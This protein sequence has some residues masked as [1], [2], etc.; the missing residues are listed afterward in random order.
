MNRFI[1]RL[2]LIILITFTADRALSYVASFF[3]SR[4][5]TTDEYK[6]NAVT[7]NMTDP[8]VLMG[9]SR[10]HH[11]YI[12]AVLSD[13]LHTGVYNA[14]LWGM[15][16]IYFQY[17]LL[18]NILERYTPHTICLE[19]HPID[20]LQTPFSTIETVAKLSPYVNY[21]K[22]CDE[23]LKKAGLYYKFQ[24]SHLYRYNS[25]FASILTGNLTE[26]SFAAD[27]GYKR[28]TG[29]LD[30]T[31]GEIKPEKFPYTVDTAKVH[32]LQAFI[33]QCKARKITLIFLF[34]P[35]YA[36]EKSTVINIPYQIAR[37]NNI[38][39][40]NH[41]YLKGISGHAAYYFDPGHL[42]EAGA[43]KYSS[44]ISHELKGYIRKK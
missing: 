10:C 11:H 4:A 30:T 13:S 7:L 2:L 25:E 28:L 20:Y 21:S 23:V 22:G 17:G 43:V 14:G 18:C 41:Y 38:P 24:L 34:S 16:N 1:K 15:R 40:L 6:M 39:F 32:Y 9:S 36:V 26:R 19:I 27:K 29:Q 3:Y 37:K 42:N 12:P 8:V 31:Y 35:M 33:N 5:T 44:I